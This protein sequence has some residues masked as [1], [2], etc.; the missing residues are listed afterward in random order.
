MFVPSRLIEIRGMTEDHLKLRLR[1]MGQIAKDIRYTT[2]SHCWGR[3]IPF[4][5]LSSNKDALMTK[6][7][8][9]DLSRVSQ[10]AI[11]VSWRLNIRYTWIDSLCKTHRLDSRTRLNKEGII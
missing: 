9:P 5:L 1:E 10:D 4:E 2:L 11:F 7:P 6:I 8:L 3:T